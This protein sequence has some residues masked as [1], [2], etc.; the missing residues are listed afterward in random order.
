MYFMMIVMWEDA[1]RK[2]KCNLFWLEGS[3]SSFVTLSSIGLSLEF[4]CDLRICVKMWA[5]WF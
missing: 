4:D 5:E 1:E 3:I 2:E